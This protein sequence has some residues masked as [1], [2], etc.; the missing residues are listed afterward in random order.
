MPNV[1]TPP[2]EIGRK[3]EEPAKA[4]VTFRSV[5]DVAKT[6]DLIYDNVLQAAKT[7][8]AL[9]N[10]RHTL[11]L[12]N[13]R[14]RDS[15]VFP[16]SKQKQAILRGQ[17][18]N[19][20][21]AGDWELI[22]N[23]TGAVLDRRTATVA[24]IP[25]M[26]D[27]GTFIH[28][29]NEYTLSHQM[30]LRPGVFTRVKDNGEIEAHANILPGQGASH[31]YFLDPAK[32]VF[33]MRIG[34]AKIPLI[35]LLKSL[36]VTDR[37]LQEAWGND[38]YSANMQADDP[39]ALNK[40]YERLVSRREPDGDKT[41]T[42]LLREAVEKMQLDPDVS[43][44]TLGQ[45]F[46]NMS[47]DTI[48][49]TT[50]KLL[51]VSRGEQD[52]DDR[53]HMAY[54]TVLGPED[55]F[56]ER[57]EKD[58]GGMRRKLLWKAS[59]RGNLQGVPPGALSKQIE[60][61]LLT[62]RLGQAI[63]E[64]NPMEI[65][66][67]QTK[68]TR[69]GEG[70]IPS[71]DSVPDEARSVQPS[72]MGFIDPVRTPESFRAGV[73]VNI[74]SAVEKGSDGRLYITL[75][76]AKTGKPVRKSPQDLVNASI[77]FPWEM[78]RPTKRVGAMSGGKMK[79][80]P[81]N[82]VDYVLPHFERAFSPLGNLVPM[83]SAVKPQRTAMASRM[84]TQALPLAGAEAPLVRSGVPGKEGESFESLYGSTAGAV[85]AQRPGRVMA[86][87]PDGVKIKY[88]DGKTETVEL[89]DYFP[90]NRKTLLYNTPMVRPGD[91]VQP[92]DLL[93]KSN[94]TDDKGVVAVGKN[95]RVGY[96]PFKGLDFEDAIVVSES[97]AKKLSSEHMYQQGLD[98]DEGV[99]GGKRF[100]L[101]AFPGKYERKMLDRMDDDGVIKPGE[102][103]HYD[104][105][106]VLAARQVES[107][108][109]RVHKKG[110]KS[111]RDQTDVW[112]HHSPGLVTDVVKTPQGASVLVKSLSETQVGD[113]LCYDGETSFLT[114]DRGWVKVSDVTSADSLAT[115]NPNTE[116][117]EWQR[118]THV[119]KYR[120][121]GEMYRLVTKQ[122]DMLVTMDHRIWAARPGK[123]YGPVT[124]RELWQSKG[125]W[126][127]KKDV[128]W[129]GSERS[130][131]VFV[132]DA[133]VRSPKTQVLSDVDMDDWL[134]FLG[135][136][137]SEG[138]CQLSSHGTCKT[139][140][141]GQYRA[142]AHWKKIKR[143]L[144]RLG[145]K[146][147]YSDDY[148]RF[149]I[150]NA[151]LYD[152]LVGLGDSYSK[153]VPEFVQE[154]SPRQIFKF[155]DAYLNGDGHRGQCW[156]YSTSS[157]RLAYDIQLLCLKV[158]WNADVREQTREDNWATHRHWRAR[159]NRYHLRPG[160]RKRKAAKYPS[161]GESVVNYDGHVYCV[162]V[163]NHI[164]LVKRGK[165]SYLSLN[166][167]RYG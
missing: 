139:V 22:D 135:Y 96:L 145:L 42:Q 18:L 30:R 59:F 111:W 31:R 50:K 95:L 19:R 123:A 85:R 104:D 32:A 106:L 78:E 155:L 88:D 55:L 153:R 113:K 148:G 109:G 10:Q 120:H 61:A 27:R 97:A 117:L 47:L 54:Q 161:T 11:R 132:P 151:W 56:R 3:K 84:I 144:K 129:A 1:L 25:A 126:R 127:F 68:I 152:Q 40:L 23:A 63:E 52:I 64:I 121:K 49:A 146:Y 7:L 122:V 60:A 118:P 71:I 24:A 9:S 57:L 101:G 166:S 16:I 65:H 107:T 159:I 33:Y 38:V 75:T 17:S 110:Q 83:K 154:L 133:V 134:E 43:Q 157:E 143:L 98:W 26:T 130:R 44:Q 86:V 62:S 39:A 69:L 115:M 80:V 72:H 15:G 45:P 103:V 114:K 136:Y 100:Y 147:R 82:K 6:R 116:E 81:R 163:P 105:P 140:R 67:K 48:M 160:F 90:Y 35:P 156:E 46:K 66:D 58:Y 112:K 94:Y 119:W 131:F 149:E 142:S 4:P 124:A 53:D 137:I 92:G 108:Y 12:A 73:D 2:T 21:L 167:G 5:G 77:A 99:K 28:N 162:T 79:F 102:I 93:A 128:K 14:Y 91:R 36:G 150:G 141:I 164:L 51:A 29:G 125:E 89:Y 34:Q 158:G 138:W 41:K 70:G 76:D 37:Q 74:A 8:P 20:R 87:N 13:V 165:K